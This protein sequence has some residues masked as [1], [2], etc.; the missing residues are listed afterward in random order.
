MKSQDKST[1]KTKIDQ[2]T[3]NK[4]KRRK[5][6]F[7]SLCKRFPF[8]GQRILNNL[9]DPTLAKFRKSSRGMAEFLDN[10][11]FYWIRA[12]KKY[13]KNLEG[14]EDSWKEIFDKT[15]L[16]VTKQLIADAQNFFKLYPNSK[17][18]PLHVAADQS[19]LQIFRY[20]NKVL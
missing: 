7:N 1:R 18:T 20:V 19:T 13:S 16:D 14:Y 6:S 11:R 8:V 4:S 9:N 5:I 12:L 3:I 15:P 17:V 10:E 2:K